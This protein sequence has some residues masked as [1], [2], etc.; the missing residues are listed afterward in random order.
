[1][2]YLDLM[3]DPLSNKGTAFSIEERQRLGLAGLLPP[4]VELIDNQAARAL[5]AV[6]AK[7]TPLEKYCY[8]A[9][10][11]NENETL[12]FRT[13]IDNLAELV[14]IVY[15]PTVGQACLDW[16][17]IYVRPRGLYITPRERGHIRTVLRRWPCEKVG[18]IVV[19]DGGRILGLGDL[20]ANGMGIP[21]GKL[22]LYV[23]CAGID[24][25]RCLPVMLDVGTDT[26][27][28]RDDPLYLGLRQ[29]RFAGPAYDAL[30]EE[31]VT[32]AQE[33]FP[34]VLM[35]F[36]DFAN[37]NAFRLLA[38]YRDRVCSFNDDIQG[39]GA[40]GLAGVYAA[41][42]ATKG[43]L[44]EQRFL[45]F[46]SGEANVGIATIVAAALE[47]AG[48]GA[49]EARQRCW[50]I[51]SKGLVIKGRPELAEH[52][53]PFAHDHAPLPDLLSTVQA[54]RPT[55]L[56]GASG[57]PGTFTEPVLAAMAGLNERPVVF[58]LSNPTSKAECTAEQ[59]YRA[60][61]GRALFAGGSPFAPVRLN[62]RT[63]VAGQGNNSYIF[64]GI[65]LAVLACGLK[66]VTDE[67]YFAAAQALA[68]QVG[69]EDLASSCIFPPASRLREVA[70]AV[71]TAVA[72]VGYS[73]AAALRPRPADLAAHIR[74]SRYVANY[75]PGQSR[76]HERSDGSTSAFE[77]VAG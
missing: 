63:Y 54:I 2:S 29:P 53:R 38:R 49:D 61:D 59:A 18:I 33:I 47:R 34:G 55:F 22:A 5:A 70:V 4:G 12:Y 66:R 56:I 6:R 28:V 8:L 1:M 37:V 52:K 74:A 46:G 42:R 67:M 11:Q 13:L 51:D 69:D 40:M 45:F 16:S 26:A 9:E 19:T 24:P 44:T 65:G 10:V 57:Q 3:H 25:A 39:T 7:S 20:G 43:A 68:G 58:A 30:V 35:Q 27:S 76:T 41:L 71:A 14:P 48:L 75:G 36:E 73:Q 31:F 64:P 32:A 15:T 60:T 17:R 72:E 77:I 62:G 50:L 23:A 21:I